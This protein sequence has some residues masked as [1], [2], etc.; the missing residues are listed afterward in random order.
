LPS[1][2]IIRDATIDDA[3]AMQAMIAGLARETIGEAQQVLSVDAMR[4]YGFGDEKSFES[5]VAERDGAV[6]A[7]VVFYDEFSTWRGGKG[8]YILDIY[9]AAAER[10]GG[11][12]RRLIAE[13]ARRAEA[14]GAG[15][16][17]LS[18]DEKNIRAIEFY[19]TL[20]FQEHA[21]DRVFVL[22]GEAMARASKA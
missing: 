22:S 4:R 13:I 10:G 7:A 11:L 20:G 12:G 15:Y 6:V 1:D 16:V 9:V 14:R 8:V 3:A 2:A 5:V 19:E 17:K 18:V 21:H